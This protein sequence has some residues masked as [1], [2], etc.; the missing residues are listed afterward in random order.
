MTK[1]IVNALIVL[2][3]LIVAQAVIFNHLGL[4]G[5]ALPIVFIYVVICL[6]APLATN[7]AMTI[8]FFSGL[9]VDI[10]S[11][12][13]GL[14]AL[15]CTLLAFVRKP[16]LHLYLPLDDELGPAPLGFRSLG[17]EVFLKYAITAVFVYCTLVFTIEAFELFNLRLWL[18]RIVCSTVYTFM[19]IYAFASLANRTQREK[20]L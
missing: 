19:F 3:V 11:D 9:A 5:V 2:A 12:T 7:W 8:G 14:N 10:F 16:L 20:K 15:S 17:A 13:A 6:P 1:T 4:F 18:L